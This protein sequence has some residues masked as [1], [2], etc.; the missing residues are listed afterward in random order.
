MSEGSIQKEVRW[1][2]VIFFFSAVQVPLSNELIYLD[3]ASAREHFITKLTCELLTP[4]RIRCRLRK[5]A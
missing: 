5:G 3:V 4:F 1:E 2:R